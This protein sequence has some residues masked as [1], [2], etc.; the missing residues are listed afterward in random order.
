MPGCAGR[1]Q[2]RLLAASAFFALEDAAWSQEWWEVCPRLARI[3]RFQLDRMAGAAPAPPPPAGGAGSRRSL[4]DAALPG[5][6][7]TLLDT[8]GA[9]VLRG[10]VRSGLQCIARA[11]RAWT[12]AAA[13]RRAH[14]QMC[15]TPEELARVAPAFHNVTRNWETVLRAARDGR[16]PPPDLRNIEATIRRHP[17]EF[18]VLVRVM[19]TE[20]R[21]REF[22][23]A[24]CTDGAVAGGARRLL[25]EFVDVELAPE[26]VVELCRDS[27]NATEAFYQCAAASLLLLSPLFPGR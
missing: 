1:C 4:L 11:L 8:G 27:G 3:V 18:R 24:R 2:G 14:V 6:S 9:T 21:L 20:A 12:R 25:Q 5:A 17:H 15:P 26:G 7:R 19:S 13:R 22:F 10:A 16:A 23:G